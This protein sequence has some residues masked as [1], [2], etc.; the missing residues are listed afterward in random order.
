M[1]R[2][3]A[4]IQPNTADQPPMQNL[5]SQPT[6]PTYTRAAQ[7]KRPRK[8]CY[9]CRKHKTRCT[10]EPCKRCQDVGL[11]CS[12]VTKKARQTVLEGYVDALENTQSTLVEA[13]KTLYAMVR[14]GDKLR[15]AKPGELS[16][17]EMTI[18]GIL[19]QLRCMEPEVK[20][21]SPSDP[22]LSEEQIPRCTGE[23]GMEV[24]EMPRTVQNELGTRFED[25]VNIMDYH[26]SNTGGYVENRVPETVPSQYS[27]DFGPYEDIMS[28]FS[29]LPIADWGHQDAVTTQRATPPNR[30]NT[31]PVGWNHVIARIA[32]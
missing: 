11:L 4:T 18:S 21:E 22:S 12:S 28:T 20:V 9:A 13:I 27:Y 7:C 3:L 1:A 15:A 19:S 29:G 32:Y 10:G 24:E 5:P 30:K 14:N 6:S 31:G 16:D 2:K 23:A 8:A 17:D 25:S 26:G